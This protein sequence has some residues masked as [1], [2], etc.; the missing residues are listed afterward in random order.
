MGKRNPNPLAI[1]EEKQLVVDNRAA[2]TASKVVQCGARFVISWSGIREIVGRV[3]LRTIPQFIKIPVK[4]V[5]TGLCNVVDLRRAVPPL[6]DG[7]RKCIDRHFR[8]RIQSEDKVCRESAVQIRQRIIRF[9]A[10]DDIA[11]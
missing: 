6:I 2:H 11:V 10:I 8:Y 9:Q 1:E 3:E 5:R 4:L 7:I